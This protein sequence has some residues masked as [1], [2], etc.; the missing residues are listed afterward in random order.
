MADHPRITDFYFVRHG[1][2][3]RREGH[4]PPYD[5]PLTDGPF[6]LSSLLQRLPKNADWHISPLARTQATA[7]L[8]HPD[9]APAS[10]KLDE[11]LIEMS[12]GNWHDSPVADVWTQL[13]SRP[14]HNWSFIMPDTEPPAG[15]SFN[16]QCAR[17]K[18]WLD[19]MAARNLNRPQ[20]IIAHSGV[21]RAALCHIL[22]TKPIHTIGIPIAH[23]ACMTATLMEAERATDAGGAWQFTGLSG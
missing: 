20:I 6:D 21:I 14:K 5:A 18:I 16:E 17:I 8:L 7:A 4:L 11:R 1:P 13:N 12:F 10:L 2:V 9:L 3:V 23:F 19:E 22:R 15:D